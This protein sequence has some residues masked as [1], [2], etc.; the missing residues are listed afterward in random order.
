MINNMKY[1][2]EYKICIAL[3][4]KILFIIQNNYFFYKKF[5]IYKN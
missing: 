3:R 2:I 5:K 1:M 4:F